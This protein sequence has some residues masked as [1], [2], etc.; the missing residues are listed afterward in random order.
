MSFW[1]ERK[2]N[3]G[4]Q[5]KDVQYF[6]ELDINIGNTFEYLQGTKKRKKKF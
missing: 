2:G 3:W 5:M 1:L 4:K 6:D